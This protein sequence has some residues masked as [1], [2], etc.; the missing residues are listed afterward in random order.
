MY[1]HEEG[2]KKSDIERGWWIFEIFSKV[3]ISEAVHGR[4]SGEKSQHF[5]GG[6][7][8]SYSKMK[9]TT[10]H[11]LRCET[12]SEQLWEKKRQTRERGL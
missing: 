2:E 12:T 3:R 7:T 4:E 6:T 11:T 5:I 8:P 10:Y 9:N 1:K